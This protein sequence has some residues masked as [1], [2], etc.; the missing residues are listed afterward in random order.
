MVVEGQSVSRVIYIDNESIS[1]V[2]IRLCLRR[3]FCSQ[4]SLPFLRRYNPLW[5]GSV[6]LSSSVVFVFF[7]VGAFAI[8]CLP[9]VRGCNDRTHLQPLRSVML[10]HRIFVCVSIVAGQCVLIQLASVC[11]KKPQCVHC[12]NLSND[13]SSSGSSSLESTAL[14]TSGR[15]KRCERLR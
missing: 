9:F 4:S 3:R 15:Y 14:S 5:L 2:R 6:L 8:S 10:L 12:M 11:F 7:S 13:S 1:S